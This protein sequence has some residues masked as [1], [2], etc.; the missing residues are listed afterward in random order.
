MLHVGKVMKPVS[1]DPGLKG[2]TKI[3]KGMTHAGLQDRH[4]M[5]E[6][7]AVQNDESQITNA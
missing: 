6:L 4:A 1:H 2:P 5:V 7:P 3:G